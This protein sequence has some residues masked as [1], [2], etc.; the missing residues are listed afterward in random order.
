MTLNLCK[1]HAFINYLKNKFE[2]LLNIML[3]RS[4]S[5]LHKNTVLSLGALVSMAAI[6][7]LPN[8]G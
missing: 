2:I 6:S 3:I 5:K 8:K 4:K 7:L 1:F